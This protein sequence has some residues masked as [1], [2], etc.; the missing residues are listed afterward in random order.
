MYTVEYGLLWFFFY[1]FV[2]ALMNKL[3]TFSWLKSTYDRH[4]L[5]IV[6]NHMDI[7]QFNKSPNI[8]YLRFPTFYYELCYNEYFCTYIFVYVPDNFLRI[9]FLQVEPRVKGCTP[10]SFCNWLPNCFLERLTDLLFVPPAVCGNAWSSMLIWSRA[11][12]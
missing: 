1:P 2:F 10:W 11:S 6:F 12:L 4:I 8:R 7:L 5:G 9:Y 3:Q